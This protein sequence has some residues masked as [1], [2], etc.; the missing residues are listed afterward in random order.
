VPNAAASVTNAGNY[1]STITYTCDRGYTLRGQA[2]SG[3]VAATLLWEH[4]APAC[5]ANACPGLAPPANGQVVLSNGGLFPSVATYSCD[6][7]Y[8]QAGGDRTRDCVFAESWDRV[9]MTCQGV[10]CTLPQTLVSG[11]ASASSVRYP[12]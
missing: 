9:A 3:C 6:E 2:S 7:G 11:R 4:P 10:L 8:E 5:E 1:P 12:G